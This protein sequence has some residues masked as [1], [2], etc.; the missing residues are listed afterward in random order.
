MD[1]K[2]IGEQLKAADAEMGYI[3]KMKGGGNLGMAFIAAAISE[4]ASAVNRLA[5]ALEGGGNASLTDEDF[6]A[7]ARGL[8][9]RKPPDARVKLSREI[10]L[11]YCQHCGSAGCS[12]ECEND[13]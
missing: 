1:G 5:D 11:G 6:V 3:N 4:H 13:E 12:G 2:A 8:L 9:V 10:M 7:A